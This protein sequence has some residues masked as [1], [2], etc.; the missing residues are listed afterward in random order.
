MRHGYLWVALAACGGGSRPSPTPPVVANT[1]LAAPSCT[2]TADHVLTLVNQADDKA[3]R[4]RDAIETRC[5]TDAWPASARSCIAR[6]QSLAD[7]QHCKQQ[8][9]SEQ[10]GALEVAL[11]AAEQ[12]PAAAHAM[13]PTKVS[14]E[15]QAYMRAMHGFQSCEKVPRESR[16]AMKQGEDAM[17]AAFATPQDMPA[18]AKAAMADACRQGTDALVKAAAAMGC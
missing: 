8:L 7:P 5:T 4:M 1:P 12:D 9:S 2:A 13:D 16:D 6:T 18:E 15:C 10:R 11:A 14:V 17:V 3:K